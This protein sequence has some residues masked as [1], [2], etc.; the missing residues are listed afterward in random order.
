MAG[1][2]EVDKDRSQE[3][4]KAYAIDGKGKRFSDAARMIFGQI[5]DRSWNLVARSV[6]LDAG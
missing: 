3:V 4:D 1:E 2:S 6:L 5:R